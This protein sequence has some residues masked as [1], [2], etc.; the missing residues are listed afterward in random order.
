MDSYRLASVLQLLICFTFF[1]VINGKGKMSVAKAN[2]IHVPQNDT[3]EDKITEGIIEVISMCRR[4]SKIK[5]CACAIK[6]VR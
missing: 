4:T 2:V 6:L 5:K 1:Y 3:T